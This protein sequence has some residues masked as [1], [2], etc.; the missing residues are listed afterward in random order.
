MKAEIANYINEKVYT[1]ALEPLFCIKQQV[2]K[3]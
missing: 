3:A 2:T 1:A